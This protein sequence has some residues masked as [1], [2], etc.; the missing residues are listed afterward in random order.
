MFRSVS[1]FCA[2]ANTFVTHVLPQLC[3]LDN[4]EYVCFTIILVTYLDNKLPWYVPT[5][6][7]VFARIRPLQLCYWSW[8]LHAGRSACTKRILCLC[9]PPPPCV[10]NIIMWN[11]LAQ[12]NDYANRLWKSK[13]V[14]R[15]TTWEFQCDI[16]FLYIFVN[17]NTFQESSKNISVIISYCSILAIGSAN[18]RR[19]FTVLITFICWVHMRND[20]WIMV[21]YGQGRFSSR[22]WGQMGYCR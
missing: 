12:P 20:P 19:R 14:V 21:S 3:S 5:H 6:W 7:V 11:I 8:I 22:H 16:S 1:Y 18:G 15:F 9:S 10:W 2:N 17:T 13:F 4:S